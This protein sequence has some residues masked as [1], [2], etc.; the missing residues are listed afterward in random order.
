MFLENSNEDKNIFEIL[1]NA[2]INPTDRQIYHLHE[3]WRKNKNELI[4]NKLRLE[5]KYLNIKQY[6]ETVYGV[7]SEKYNNL[8]YNVC[9]ETATCDCPNGQ[10]GRFCKHLCAVELYS[11][12]S[13]SSAPSLSVEDR[14]EFARIALGEEIPTEFFEDMM[15]APTDEYQK[16]DTSSGM[17]VNYSHEWELQEN[18]ENVATSIQDLCTD[19]LSQNIKNFLKVI[20]ENKSVE[21]NNAVK[22]FNQKLSKLTTPSDIISFFH[23]IKSVQRQRTIRVQP[24]SISRRRV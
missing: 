23:N 15:V 1:S 6:Q 10:G 11:S 19:E 18:L 2:Q 22:K 9:T 14:K 8:I 16:H 24:T 5:A 3:G 21:M 20:E 17:E 13:L 4:H 12:F 7:C